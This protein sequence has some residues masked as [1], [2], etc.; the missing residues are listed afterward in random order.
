MVGLTYLINTIERS[1]RMF[2]TSVKEISDI[3]SESRNREIERE[4]ERE[5]KKTGR[6]EET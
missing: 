2:E 5:R 1:D 3:E 6:D 4:K